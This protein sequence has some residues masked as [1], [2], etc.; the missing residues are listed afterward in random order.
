ML[1]EKEYQREKAVA[2]ARKWAFDRN[3]RYLD[4]ANL[5]G[6]CTNFISQCLYAGAG[7]QNY[8][9]T[10]GWYYNSAS[11]R[12][13][14]W[15]G[16]PYQYDFLM[17]NTGTGPYGRAAALEELE[18]GDTIQLGDVSGHFYHNLLVC[19]VSEDEILICA[20]DFDAYMRPLSSYEFAQFRCIKILGV[21][22]WA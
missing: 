2:Y 5:G 10:F 9:P 6:D 14:S 11:D 21:R 17:R 4:F 22:A 8:T 3:P 13:P 19:A 15:T 12:T 1:K 7:V 16:V 20:H 18:I